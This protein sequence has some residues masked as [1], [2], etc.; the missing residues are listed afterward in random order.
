MILTI[1]KWAL[2]ALIT[3]LLTNEIKVYA[4]IKRLSNS[5]TKT[6]YIP[7]IGVF[8]YYL[9]ATEEDKEHLR[10]LKKIVNEADAEGKKALLVNTPY[11]PK[12]ITFPLDP[13]LTGELAMKEKK[14][15]KK[16][17]FQ[18][19]PELLYLGF[20][21]QPHD[22]ALKTRGAFTEVFRAENLKKISVAIEEIMEKTM[23]DLIQ[24]KKEEFKSKG[25]VDMDLR[26]V[27]F[28]FQKIF[29]KKF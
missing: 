27:I 29:Q 25:Y 19:E 16:I 28:T 21:Y 14:F 9:I 5:H 18:R 22:Q 6:I 12:P 15:F 3:Y 2:I 7:F 8:Y 4:D 24:E 10:W 20:M 26:P 13:K 17:T 11:F 1:L 23:N